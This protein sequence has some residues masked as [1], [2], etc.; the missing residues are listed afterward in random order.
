MR[1]KG[2]R[3][4]PPMGSNCPAAARSIKV[5]V[6]SR[7]LTKARNAPGRAQAKPWWGAQ[8]ERH[9]QFFIE[10]GVFV[11]EVSVLPKGLAMVGG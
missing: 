3:L 1:K 6:T 5:G 8:H 4:R 11:G 9:A 7:V 2:T 10:K